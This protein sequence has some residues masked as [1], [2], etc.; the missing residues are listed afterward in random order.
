MQGVPESERPLV[1]SNLLDTFRSVWGYEGMSTPVF[2]QYLYNS[3]AA[4][5]DTP[6]GTLLGVKF[7]LTTRYRDEVLQYVTDPVVKDFW[8]NDFASM[9]EEDKRTSVQ[10]TVNKFQTLMADARVRNCLGQTRGLSLKDIVD[11]KKILLVRLPRYSLGLQKTKI[12]G[13]LLISMLPPC[14]LFIDDAHLFQTPTLVELFS[15]GEVTIAH[16]YLSQF[17][18]E[19]QDALFGNAVT[20]TAFRTGIKDAEILKREFYVD[21]LAFDL[22]ELQTGMIRVATE[23][24][25]IKSRTGRCCPFHMMSRFRFNVPPNRL[26]RS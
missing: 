7:L 23:G 21:N 16:Q 13:S 20:K 2:D 22:S 26:M 18:R 4:L 3:L 17:D 5:L 6:N 24:G 1:A 15:R 12:L 10:S 9:P 14:K 19:T 11:R 8:E 25:V